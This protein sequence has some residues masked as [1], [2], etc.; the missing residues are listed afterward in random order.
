MADDDATTPEQAPRPC[1]PCRSTGRIVSRLGGSASTD[2]CPWC[3]G[4]GKVIPGHDA[5]A[6]RRAAAAAEPPDDAA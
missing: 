3:E 2:T 6:V 5:Q 4:T 1:P